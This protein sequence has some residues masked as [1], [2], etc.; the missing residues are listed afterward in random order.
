MECKKLIEIYEKS[1]SKQYAIRSSSIEYIF[2]YKPDQPIE[3][4]KLQVI[5][6]KNCLKSIELINKFC[7]NEIKNK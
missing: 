7:I 3:V 4:E 1:C 2:G 6:D 5:A